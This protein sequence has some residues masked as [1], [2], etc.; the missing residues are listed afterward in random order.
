M[1]L[2]YYILFEDRDQGMDM[3]VRLDEAGLPNR[4]APAPHALRGELSCG[5]SLMID[6]DQIKAVQTFVDIHHLPYHRIASLDNQLQSLR[7]RYC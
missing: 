7:D 4:I 6:P 2:K 1:S 3:H 5:I